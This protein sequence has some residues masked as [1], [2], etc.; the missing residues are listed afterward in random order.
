[1]LMVSSKEI[2]PQTRYCVYCRANILTKTSLK[3]I[4]SYY[5]HKTEAT[6]KDSIKQRQQEQ[7][8][9]ITVALGIPP[10]AQKLQVARR[11]S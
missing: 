3:E 5:F 4:L 8:Q 11:Q 1:M 9:S 6:E 2:Q 7:K 10:L